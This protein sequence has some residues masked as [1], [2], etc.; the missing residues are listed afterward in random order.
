MQSSDLFSHIDEPHVVLKREDSAEPANPAVF[1]DLPKKHSTREK[2]SAAD[3][4]SA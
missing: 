2:Q 4:P 1:S 3:K